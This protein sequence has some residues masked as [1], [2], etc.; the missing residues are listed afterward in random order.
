M[1][2]KLKG[3]RSVYM[4]KEP[5]DKMDAYENEK[6]GCMASDF[7]TS[8]SVHIGTFLRKPLLNPTNFTAA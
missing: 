4:G 2:S 3:Y 7:C 6:N 1:G 8:P 5:Y